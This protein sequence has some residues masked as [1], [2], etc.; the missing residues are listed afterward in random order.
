MG[1]K[2]KS[3]PLNNQKTG[4]FIGNSISYA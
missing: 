1:C 2:G 3:L 4:L